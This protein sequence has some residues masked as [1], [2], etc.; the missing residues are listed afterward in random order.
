[1]TNSGTRPE[2]IGVVPDRPI[3][4]TREDLLANRDPVLEAAAAWIADLVKPSQK[5][6]ADA[7]S[8]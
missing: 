6:N 1:M 8:K 7:P 4:W 5:P 2:G 3:A